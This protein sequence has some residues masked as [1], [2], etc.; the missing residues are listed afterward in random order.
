MKSEKNEFSRSTVGSAGPASPRPP[1][2]AAH[3]PAAARACPAH[4]AGRGAPAATPAPRQQPLGRA[5]TRAAGSG[6]GG[7]RSVGIKKVRAQPDFKTRAP[8]LGCVRQVFGCGH[9][10]YQYTGVHC[11][12]CLPVGRPAL[13]LL[14]RSHGGRGADALGF[15]RT[16]L[17]HPR[18]SATTWPALYLLSPSYLYP[19]SYPLRFASTA[20]CPVQRYGT[21]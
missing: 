3:R 8:L 15:R 5:R 10:D 17:P 6:E 16:D 9:L 19:R 4:D 2:A 12:C 18:Q 14:V 11:V 7:R 13:R 21:H 20:R 1:L